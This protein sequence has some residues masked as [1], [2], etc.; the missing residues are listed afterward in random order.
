MVRFAL[1]L[2]F[3]VAASARVFVE[4][5]FKLS[6]KQTTSVRAFAL[7][8]ALLE[9]DNDKLEA[10]LLKMDK[11]D[12]EQITREEAVQYLVSGGLNQDSAEA[13]CDSLLPALDNAKVD[14]DTQVLALMTIA[15]L[16]CEEDFIGKCNVA[17]A[18]SYVAEAPLYGCD[19]TCYCENQ[20]EIYLWT[21][22]LAKDKTGLAD[23]ENRYSCS[24]LTKDLE[25]CSCDSIEEYN[26]E[27]ASPVARNAGIMNM[28]IRQMAD[29]GASPQVLSILAN[30]G[31]TLT[32]SEAMQQMMIA[33]MGLSPTMT[34]LLLNG[35]KFSDD[36]AEN[37]LLMLK[38]L[39]KSGSISVEMLPLLGGDP[40]AK[41]YLIYNMIASGSIDAFV[42]FLMLAGSDHGHVNKDVLMAILL[43]G[44][45]GG[46][47]LSDILAGAVTP[48]VP[49]LPEGIFPGSELSFAHFEAL[50]VSTCAL[51][52]L[53][54]RFACGHIGIS[55]TDCEHVPYCCYAP[56]FMSDAQVAS[57]TGGAIEAASSVPWCFYNVFFVFPD[58][59]HLTVQGIGGFPAAHQCPPLF[60]F[61]LTLDPTTT[62]LMGGNLGSLTNERADCGFPGITEF[63]CVAIRGCCFDPDAPILTPQCYQAVEDAP[64]ILNAPVPDMF[65]G[66][67]GTCDLNLYKVPFLYYHR[68]PCH[69]GLG[70]YQ[71]G[72]DILQE[73]T[74]ED[75][76]TRLNC[77]WEPSDAVAEKYPNVPRCYQKLVGGKE[78]PLPVS[79][80]DLTA[81]V[82]QLA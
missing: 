73:P 32:P 49:E 36:E 21:R 58:T 72:F 15:N 68:A 6:P 71:V 64:T 76:L 7:K 20:K 67:E 42:G 14:E 8:A 24:G 77:C 52:D 81:R 46:K 23:F 79:V 75:C 55:A 48:Y 41:D 26:E 51:H 19:E 13:C 16:V 82:G 35:G 44:L 25:A 37:K 43:G 54:N 18:L 57:S 39:A 12:S 45:T 62:A 60:K 63:H 66:V 5:G 47:D 70:Q 3:V 10:L 11:P 31:N 17:E 29:D 78:S 65:V 22:F 69:Y 74:K 80:D 59:F 38:F 50:G 61:G 40:E 1:F 28:L 56:V 4:E 53:Q 30:M 2:A 9:N 34:H 27:A 33:Q